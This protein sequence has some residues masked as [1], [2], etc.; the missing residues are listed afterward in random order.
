MPRYQEGSGPHSRVLL[1]GH[2]ARMVS[3]KHVQRLGAVGVL[4]Q[5]GGGVRTWRAV[6]ED[7]LPQGAGGEQ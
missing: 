3:G 2:S 1:S 5:M 6:V 7:K 4:R